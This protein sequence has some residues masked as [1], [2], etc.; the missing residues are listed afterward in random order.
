MQLPIY[1]I[2]IFSVGFG[3]FAKLEFQKGDFLIEY[4]GIYDLSFVFYFS[5]LSISYTSL[6][7]ICIFLYFKRKISQILWLCY[8]YYLGDVISPSEGDKREKHYDKEQKGSYIF[9]NVKDVHGKN[10]W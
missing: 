7:F 2:L 10:I 9:Y 5:V 4:R 1:K 3:L 6:H 8:Y